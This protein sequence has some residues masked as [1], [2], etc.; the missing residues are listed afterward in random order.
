MYQDCILFQK[1]PFSPSASNSLDHKVL[2][3]NKLQNPVIFSG[4]PAE[5]VVILNH[6]G[7]V[8]STY[9]PS[10]QVKRGKGIARSSG[11]SCSTL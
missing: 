11:Q 7:M 5:A 6:S 4:L 9:I 1:S 2:A 10:I 8:A 3:K